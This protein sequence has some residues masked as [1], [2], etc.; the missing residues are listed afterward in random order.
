MK[1]IKCGI[2]GCGVIAPSHIES[3]Q[4]MPGAEVIWACDIVKQKAVDT[5]A[6]YH[7]PRV[8]TDFMEL[9]ADPDLDAVSICTDHSSHAAIAIAALEA[10]KHVLCEKALTISLTSLEAMEKVHAA[11]PG[12]VFAGVFQHRHEQLTQMLRE[13]VERKAFG[14]ISC[15]N[16]NS[17]CWRSNDYYRQDQWRGTWKYEGGSLL[18]NQAIHF[19]DLYQWIGGG[20]AELCA[21][22]E[23]LTHQGVIETEDTAAAAVRFKSGAL[24]AISATSSSVEDWRHV[25]TISGN[26]G[27]VELHNDELVYYKF[28]R[29]EIQEE[30]KTR[31]QAC[32]DEKQLQVGKQYYGE[33]HPAQIK[34]F[35]EAIREKRDPYV[36]AAAARDAVRIVLA[37]YESSQKGGWVKLP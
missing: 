18:I 11:H 25:L 3:Y 32:K 29:P 20:V 12:L 21:R 8:A 17:N 9:L 35:V 7:I 13:L 2:I 34:D 16:L 10:G 27:F 14:T 1:T 28:T 37:C 31:I 4:N 24:G 33:G 19:I 30:V 26:E 5:A 15:F 22:C 6:K 23:N 36:P